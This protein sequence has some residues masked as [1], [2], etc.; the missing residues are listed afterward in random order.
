MQNYLELLQHILDHGTPKMDRTGTGTRSIFGHQLRFDLA[1][2]FPLV[3]PDNRAL[4]T[5][6]V[7][8]K[9]RR[10]LT[11]AQKKICWP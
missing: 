3:T 7:I 1:A 5:L 4:G 10:T 2:G 11:G 8:D 6:C 9:V